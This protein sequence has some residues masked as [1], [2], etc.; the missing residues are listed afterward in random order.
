MPRRSRS[1]SP[2]DLLPGSLELLVL[3]TLSHGGRH[4]YG[5]RSWVEEAT[6]GVLKVEEGSLYPA[7]QRMER[8]GWIVAEWGLSEHGRRAKFYKMTQRGLQQLDE[9]TDRWRRFVS[10]VE[11][12]LASD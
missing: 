10:A 2:N 5:I 6:E 1:P 12:V 9:Q 3:R 11:G 4:G 7:L 8:R